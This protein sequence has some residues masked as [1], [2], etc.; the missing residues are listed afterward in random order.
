MVFEPGVLGDYS[1]STLSLLF[2][3][4]ELLSGGDHDIIVWAHAFGDEPACFGRMFERDFHTH[5][6][7]A[8][9]R[10]HINPPCTFGAHHCFTWNYDA[11]ERF[12]GNL[13]I[14]C[15]RLT[16]G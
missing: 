15:H 6:G 12:A 9:A 3:R 1:F 10:V 13:E 5:K 4:Q 11:F 2:N 16:W 8:P 14:S 7:L